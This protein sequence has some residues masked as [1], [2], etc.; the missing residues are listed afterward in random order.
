M[1]TIFAVNTMD[2][3]S[4]Q[5]GFLHA[6][7]CRHGDEP[8]DAPRRNHPS[9]DLTILSG[10]SLP[11]C[12]FSQPFQPEEDCH[13]CGGLYHNASLIILI[14]IYRHTKTAILFV[15]FYQEITLRL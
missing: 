5:P 15:I 4:H 2:D 10:I 6:I 7:F 14:H 8:Y 13:I 12:D 11:F 9:E 1:N 3:Y